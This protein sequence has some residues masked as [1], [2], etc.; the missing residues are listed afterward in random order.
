MRHRWIVP[1]PA[2]GLLIGWTFALAP[3]AAA[4]EPR[5]KTLSLDQKE[6]FKPELSISSSH[7][8][9]EQVLDALPNKS[10][11]TVFMTS[12]GLTAGG[13]AV[14]YVDPR[15]G[16][17]TNIIGA[18]PLIPGRG[19]GNNLTLAG[20][21]A[22][23]GRSD[24]Q[25]GPALVELAVRGF[26]EGHRTLLGIDTAQLGAA[27]VTSINPE[28]WQVHIP[29]VYRGIPVRHGR[30]G[31]S[32][33]HG[34]LV[35]IG[36][37]TWGDVRLASVKPLIT[38]DKAV[39]LGFDYAGG[40][41]SHDTIAEPVRLEIVP[42]APAQHQQGARF[43]GPVG[44]GYGHRLVWAFSFERAYEPA[45]W[46]VLVDASNGEVLAFQDTL[47]AIQKQITGGIYPLTNTEVCPNAAQCGTMQSGYPM[48]FADTGLAAPNDFT[49][50]AGIFDWTS[51]AVTTTLT[52]KYIDIAD[53][54]GAVSNSSTTGDLNLGGT[55]GQHNCTSA[56]GST[57][58]TP[59]ARSAFYELNKINEMGRGWLPSNTWLQ[60]R[61]VAEVNLTTTTCNAFW[62]GSR[63][64][65]YQSGGGCRNTG[66]EA[67]VF[68]HEWGHGF[69]DNDANGTITNSGEAFAD[70]ASL[71]RL[72]ASCVGH[73]F[74]QTVDQ[75]CGQTADGTGF[76]VDEDQ[77]AGT[78]CALDCSGVRE[79]D[80]AKHAANAPSTPLGFV[81][82]RCGTGPGPCGRQV[83]C[84]ASPVRQAAWDLP[85]RDLQA[86]P[87][88]L[89][90]QS[91][92]IT[93]SRLFFQGSGNIGTWH[94]CTCG[95]GGSSSGCGATNGYM[96][97]I[98][99]DDDNGN[100]NDGTPHMT[101][102]H[103]AY[104]RH[105]IA[106]ATPT[107]TNAGCAGGPTA[108]P[109][110]TVTPGNYQNA[111]SWTT[112]AGATRYWVFRT[113]GHAGC[114]YGKALI[115][116]VTSTTYTDTQVANGRT[117]YYNVVAAG[118]SSACFG[119]ASACVSG[120]PT[121]GG[122]PDFGIACSPA[123][124]S[125]A[126]GGSATSTCTVTST[127]GFNSAVALSCSGQP[128]GV[129]CG[130]SPA[131]VTPPAN[132]S[133]NATLTV[134]VAAGTAAGTSTFQARGTNGATVRNANVTLTI[135]GGGGGAQTAT[136]DATLRAPKCASVGISCDSGASLLLGRGTVGP[137]PNQPNVIGTACADGTSGTFHSDE[138]N[139]RI[140]VSTVDG[141]NLAAGKQVRIDATVWA[142]TTPASDKLDLYYAA[143]ANSPT[144]TFL[145]TLTP[146]AAGAQTLSATYTLPAGALQAVRAQFRYQG[147]A[148]TCTTGSYNDR[149]DLVFAVQ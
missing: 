24:T 66:E 21:A 70:I 38:G 83:H 36:T 144:W 11:W 99:A 67:S 32:L 39:E 54:C 82:T 14:V 47:H 143:N 6:F 109:T 15:S 125:A 93:A 4:I 22:Q 101:A 69:D 71:Y 9:L 94:S 43:A 115:A 149:D 129:T 29:Q 16:A 123:S 2:L 146:A 124:M 122:T 62:T 23:H 10:A 37:E 76:N 86:A 58:N 126:A 89:D 35:V 133:V 31:A 13:Q 40:R 27:R 17:V 131:S 97:W 64:Q 73:G 147:A 98:T 103:A 28:L 57:G 128:A 52:G 113:E 116:T 92:F 135:T 81:C 63:V 7:E 136:F 108:A 41:S 139:D 51:G 134:S 75:G 50:S 48:P 120:T 88:S 111:L 138:S 3:G 33:S 65:F 18:F 72:Q 49:N 106:C 127:G 8:P 20:V 45:R 34:N 56:G 53:S 114:N 80:W 90:S 121:A 96:Q 19:V 26:I 95:A 105:A 77:T 140:K 42:V 130:Y 60:S 79:A 118:A 145:T 119:R 110:L 1:G 5:E 107:P 84:S 142:W 102:I 12:E 148:G 117:Y 104:N 59:S 87:F 68:D 44:Q 91:A 25:V 74:W 55:N 30:L 78:Y 112:V 137:E 46:E 141:T 100:L 132:G 61:V 85:A